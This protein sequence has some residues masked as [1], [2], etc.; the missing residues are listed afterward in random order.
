MNY[1]KDVISPVEL[2]SRYRR[3]A[4]MY[5]PDKGGQL[6]IMQEIN[7]EY[8]EW[9]TGFKTK[10]RSLKEI[11]IGN[12]IYVNKS[13]CVVTEVND[14]LFKARSLFTNREAYFDR[15]TGY[16]LFNLKLRARTN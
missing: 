1:L 15:D 13:E 2:K 14:R 11:R 7:R 4:F 16:G 6:D 8:S 9:E 10:P 12:M 5:H 3:L